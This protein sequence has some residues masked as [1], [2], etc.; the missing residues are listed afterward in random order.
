MEANYYLAVNDQRFPKELVLRHEPTALFFGHLHR[1][2]KFTIGKTDLLSVH[3]SN[4]TNTLVSPP[5]DPIGFNVARVYKD[6]VKLE[7]IPINS[8]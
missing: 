3:G 6:G 1:L 4:W 8:T 5:Y 7:F 2:E